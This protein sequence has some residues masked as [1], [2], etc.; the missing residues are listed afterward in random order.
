MRAY[1]ELEL[2][3]ASPPQTFVEPIS[4][5]EA[6]AYLRADQSPADPAD[7]DLISG[8]I[9]AARAAAEIRQNKDLVVKQ[10]DLHLDLLIGYDAIAGAAY[11]LRMNNVYNFGVGYEIELRYPLNSVEL[12]THTNSDGSVVELVNP[13]DYRLDTHRAYVLPPLGKTWPWFS[14][15]VTSA[16]LIRFTSGYTKDHPFWQNE[17][18]LVMTGMKYLISQ[19]YYS[20]LMIEPGR[21]SSQDIPNWIEAMLSAGFR[22]RVH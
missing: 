8:L 15:D 17:G 6:K 4:L 13:D 2:T 11:P 22:P 10:Q 12:F 19:W 16:V 5:A 3:Q 9:T 1:G 21:I 20:R 14:P 18:R 7:D